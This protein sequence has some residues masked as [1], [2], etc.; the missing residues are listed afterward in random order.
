MECEKL[1]AE[2]LKPLFDQAIK[3]VITREMIKDDIEPTP[4]RVTS[5]IN[6]LSH[7]QEETDPKQ[8]A[9]LMFSWLYVQHRAGLIMYSNLS[10]NNQ[11]DVDKS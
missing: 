6:T 10:S 9:I 7:W 1:G 11:N 3:E 2:E 4:E 5:R 8:R